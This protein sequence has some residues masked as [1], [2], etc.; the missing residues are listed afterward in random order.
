MDK[1]WR[2]VVRLDHVAVWLRDGVAVSAPHAG[3]KMTPFIQSR[4]ALYRSQ[5]TLPARGLEIAS[6]QERLLPGVGRVVRF[7]YAGGRA[8]TAMA[9]H[10]SKLLQIVRHRRML[11][12]WLSRSSNQR[13]IL[14]YV[15]GLTT[16]HDA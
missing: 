9:H 11:S 3:E 13:A 8:L 5:V 6:R 14:V 4:R 15:A 2:I 10:A 12:E 1:R 16:V 7:F